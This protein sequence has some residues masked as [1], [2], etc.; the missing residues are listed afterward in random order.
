MPVTLYSNSQLDAVQILEG[1][2]CNLS[3][4]FTTLYSIQMR[5]AMYTTYSTYEPEII[6]QFHA[7]L[8]FDGK[9]K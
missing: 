1:L 4:W 8:N 6:W 3:T 9:N 7:I 2:Q 5:T